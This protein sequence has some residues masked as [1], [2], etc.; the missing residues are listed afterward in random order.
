M[1]L[2]E[3]GRLETMMSCIV[4]CILPLNIIL[5]RI[6]TGPFEISYVYGTYYHVYVLLWEVLKLHHV[7]VISSLSHIQ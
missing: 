7:V 6:I 5:G 2:L 4:G 3:K 1:G